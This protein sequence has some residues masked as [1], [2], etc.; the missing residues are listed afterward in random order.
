MI[1]LICY[2]KNAQILYPQRWIDE[3]KH[4]IVNQSFKD[5][6]ILEV[7]YGGGNYRVFEDSIYE[8]ITLPTFVH[9]MNYL[10]DKCF[11][12]GYYAVGNL[13]LDDYYDVC[14]LEKQLFYIRHGWDI[15]SSN[16][17]LIKDDKPVLVHRF[18]RLNIREELAHNHNIVCHPAVMYSRRFIE[19][20]KYDP[21]LVPLEDL[22]LWQRAI[23]GGMKFK[24][25]PEVLCFHRLHPESVCNSNN[26]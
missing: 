4:S 13:N 5:F 23:E 11:K 24:I 2:H 15:V 21:S 8:S 25:A 20:Y 19:K 16:F 12:E 3:F 14:R 6:K 1:A 26:R 22:K 17:A 7:E 9:A 10:L 18:E